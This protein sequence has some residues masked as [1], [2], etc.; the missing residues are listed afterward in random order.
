MVNLMNLID[1]ENNRIKIIKAQEYD[2]QWVPAE[3]KWVKRGVNDPNPP[4]S[5]DNDGSN[6]NDDGGGS[7]FPSDNSKE[8]GTTLAPA[9]TP[10]ATNNQNDGD[11]TTLEPAKTKGAENVAAKTGTE[12][13]KTAK[14]A[15]AATAAK[16]KKAENK[17]EKKVKA[18][19]A[20]KTL[21]TPQPAAGVKFKIS[22]FA[23]YNTS[24]G[25]QLYALVFALQ[26]RLKELGH[27]QGED[28]GVFG[29]GT[30]AALRKGYFK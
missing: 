2:I 29:S 23:G 4:D 28:D 21:P 16:Q 13:T 18:V 12:P 27:Y 19:A 22:D 3:K 5:E 14:G 17:A 25:K 26:K 6:L 11:G 1:D 7:S 24:K 8:D 20:T 9:T 30:S 15:T 10:T